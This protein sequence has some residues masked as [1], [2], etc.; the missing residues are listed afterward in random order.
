MVITA[1]IHSF[2]HD[3]NGNPIAHFIIRQ[4]GKTLY[5]TKR[6]RQCGYGED[7]SDA[8]G[9]KAAALVGKDL[10]LAS[11]MGSR[12]EGAIRC[13]FTLNTRNNIKAQRKQALSV[14]H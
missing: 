1:E 8:A 7:R 5:E 9:F 6:R 10:E 13:S 14:S 4:N 11:Y 3:I 2:S 12:S